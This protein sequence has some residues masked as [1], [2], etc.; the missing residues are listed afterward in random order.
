MDKQNYYVELMDGRAFI[1]EIV[2]PGPNKLDV[3]FSINDEK[4]TVNIEQ[5]GLLRKCTLQP[6]HTWR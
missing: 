6:N 2:G 5:I 3:I 4:I 1:G